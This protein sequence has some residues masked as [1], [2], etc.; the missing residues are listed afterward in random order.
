M[1]APDDVV[2]A[3]GEVV[4][5]KDAGAKGSADRQRFVVR[6]PQTQHVAILAI[7][8]PQA[9]DTKVASAIGSDSVVFLGD[10][11]LVEAQSEPVNLIYEKEQPLRR[12][13]TN[14]GDHRDTAADS[15]DEQRRS[16]RLAYPNASAHC[17]RLAEQRDRGYASGVGRRLAV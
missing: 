15:E 6:V 2:G 10:F 12:Q 17:Q 11:V 5:D 8:A 13:R 4:A 16:A 3:K 7:R 1:L 9:E 14:L